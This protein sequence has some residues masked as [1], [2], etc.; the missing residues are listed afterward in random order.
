M[1]PVKS[2]VNLPELEQ[3][4][5]N[6]WNQND[7]FKKSNDNRKGAKEFNFYDGPPFANGLPHYGHLLANTIKDTVPRYWNM[8]GYDVDRRFGWDTHGVPVEFEVEKNEGLK[9]RQD[10][11]DMGVDKFNEKCRES[12]LHYAG[13][14]QKTITR[15]GRWVD[16]DRQ[17]RTMDPSFMESVWWVF[18]SLYDKGMVY[19]SHKVVPYSPRITA[20]LSNFEANQ[21]YQD[22]QDPAITVKF[23]LSDE[24]VCFL[25]WTTTPWTLISNLALAVG[26]EIEYV[27]VRVRE[28]DE[29][30]YLAKAL[31][32]KVFK[33]S[34]KDKEPKYEVLEEL[35][36]QDLIGKSYEP[37]FPYFKDHSNSFKVLGA[38]YVTTEDGTGIV[39]LAPAYGEDDFAAC[40]QAG[41]E[42]IDPLDDEGCFKDEIPEYKSLFV[43][44]ADKQIIKDLKDQGK[45]FKQDTIV[46]SYPM[47]ERTNGPLIYRAI[48]SWYVAVEQIKDQLVENN[49]TINWVPGHLKA[50]RMGKWLENAR[51]WAI[52][53]NRF[54]GTPL[55]IWVCD[56][57]ES[58][59]ECLGDI[60]SLE[61]KTGT[62]VEDLHKHFIDDLT[63]SCPDCGGTMKRINEVF[64]CWF[65]SGS[66]P[67][68]QLHYP[69]ENKDRFEDNF[70][71]D[72]IAE[73]LDQTR[74]WF[75]TLAVLSAALFE[76]PAF[77]NVVVNGLVL[78]SDGRKMS[79]RWRNYTPPLEL[80]D[81]FGAD[82]VRL[83]MLN[84][85][86]LRG[87]DLKFTND[88]VKETTR[89]VILPLWNSLSFMT[90]YADA[91]GWQPS[92]DLVNQA[93]K[94]SG[95]LD[96]WLISKLQTLVG[97]VHK[98]ME[99]YRL[100]NVVPNV[101]EFI[102]D[103]TN[104][105]IRQSRRK[106]WG[107]QKTM[108]QETREAY[109]TLFYVLANF[110][111]VFAPFAPFTADKLYR[112]LTE[113]LDGVA[114][115]VHLCDMPEFQEQLVD[116]GLERKMEL[117]R[118][119][120]ELGRSLRAKHQ[121]KTRQVLPGMMIIARSD[122][123]IR[124]VEEAADLIKGE[125]NLKELTFATEE[126]K[127]VRLSVKPN[128]RTLGR[129]LGKR[130][131]EFKK[132]L[133]S[134][135]QDPDAVAALLGEVEDKGQV[136]VLGETLNL[137][138]FLID[139]GPKDDRLIATHRGV[140]VLLDTQLTDELIREGLAREVVNRIQNLRKDSGFQVTDRI[141]IQ[142]AGSQMLQD[143]VRENTDY[144]ST[145]TQADSLDLVGEADVKHQFI[146]G[147]EIGDESCR[148]GIQTV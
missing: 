35:K 77:K 26:P 69:F 20:V 108:S 31:L 112:V 9:G 12:V 113:G 14:W 148:I 43:K 40:R 47:C 37:L 65:E 91:D 1:K 22:V 86:I 99:L 144:I 30:V 93:P 7:I 140:T 59:I 78:A 75:Y 63:Y 42:L 28:T 118:N 64:D 49:K 21:N 90:T 96:R 62:K 87:E 25:A 18:K 27:K 11:I 58:H 117:V 57:D 67:Y 101:L 146:E 115:S 104:W 145:E 39:H 33:K 15:L 103:L 137:E 82:S 142:F 13:E 84:S 83:Y 116:Q 55:P 114:E 71:A 8:R 131:N 120:A 19:Q 100:Y 48:P 147:F 10:I 127:Y 130:L 3:T 129:K 79:K 44:D 98:E 41:I 128:L 139:R 119:V 51:D 124:K 135:S 122:E 23:K 66:M 143:A 29:Q 6:F 133:E 136:S 34:K 4:I 76:R 138:D 56:K 60:K 52:S 97:A 24:D 72:F 123:D 73:G 53:R 16:W 68:A 38:D 111:K 46:H 126:A 141:A 121:I 107:G 134:V 109:E 74:G 85:A 105:Y 88:G 17:Y 80:I 45:L 102:E 5:L 95:E 50:G 89:A 54:W 132:H 70:P 92:A 81:E 32:D 125:L 36:G 2:S 106:F 94:V 61:E 110:A